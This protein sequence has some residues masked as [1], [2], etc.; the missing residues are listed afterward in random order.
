M[1]YF[2]NKTS[3]PLFYRWIKYKYEFKCVWAIS[4]DLEHGLESVVTAIFYCINKTLL[5]SF[6]VH[7]RKQRVRFR[8]ICNPN[9]NLTL[10]TTL[11]EI[12]VLRQVKTLQPNAVYRN[13]S[14]FLYLQLSWWVLHQVSSA[15]YQS[16]DA[17]SRSLDLAWNINSWCDKP[18]FIFIFSIPHYL[19]LISHQIRTQPNISIFPVQY[20]HSF[21]VI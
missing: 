10:N 4:T 5:V 6:F 3:V 8:I 18:V 11:Y 9:I 14:L 7:R 13:C 2:R 1:F 20:Y 17:L 15:L 16:H 19:L 12:K 21:W